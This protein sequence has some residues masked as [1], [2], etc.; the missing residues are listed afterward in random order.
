MQPKIFINGK[1]IKR[2]EDL[3][4]NVRNVLSDDNNNGVPDI[5]ENPFAL[6]GKLGDIKHLT[7]NLPDLQKN[8]PQIIQGLQQGGQKITIN[9][10]EYKNPSDMPE[11]E[12]AALKAQLSQI[13][14]LK[15]Q[16]NATP[17]S[18]D[19]TD[20]LSRTAADRQNEI[21]VTGSP[22]VQEKQ[23]RNRTALL[24]VAI[25]ALAGWLAFQYFVS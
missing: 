13:Q 15:P 5:A 11:S 19:T 24:V 22:V 12:K 23:D 1:E 6:F 21:P 9:G 8:L 17:P 3:P 2:L 18:T 7:K 16:Q 25:L 20:I 14:H 10:K 4:Q